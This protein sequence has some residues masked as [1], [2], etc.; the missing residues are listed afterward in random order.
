MHAG[1]VACWL[2]R[3]MVVLLYSIVLI[4]AYL[5]FRFMWAFMMCV[6][7]YAPLPHYN[8]R[9]MRSKDRDIKS[10]GVDDE[11]T[12][13]VSNSRGRTFFFNQKLDVKQWETPKGIVKR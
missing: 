1:L 12:E 3:F 4:V 11:W 2:I 5:P 7:I 8:K 9:K 6:G 10:D 13:H